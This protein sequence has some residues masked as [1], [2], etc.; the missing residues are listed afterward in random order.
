MV[1]AAVRLLI[2]GIK[3][4]TNF[5]TPA[6][7]EH[8]REDCFRY[9]VQCLRLIGSGFHLQYW[10]DVRFYIP[11]DIDTNKPSPTIL[12]ILPSYRSPHSTVYMISYH[13]KSRHFLTD[14]TFNNLSTQFHFATVLSRIDL[15]CRRHSAVVRHNRPKHPVSPFS[16]PPHCSDFSRILEW[17]ARIWCNF[18]MPNQWD[19]QH[20]NN[21]KK[22]FFFRLIVK[23]PHH[24]HPHTFQ[25]IRLG[26]QF[27]YFGFV[28]IQIHFVQQ[29]NA[30]LLKQTFIV[31]FQFFVQSKNVFDVAAVWM[32]RT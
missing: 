4:C 30:R 22:R 15:I 9:V 23:I 12:K 20:S 29:Q 2:A 11:D 5:Y 19:T 10:T 1:D 28:C 3:L 16:H 27:R 17:S 7:I 14:E 8:K 24:R 32:W 18:S 31:H 21:L 13:R 6:S 25:I 26:Y